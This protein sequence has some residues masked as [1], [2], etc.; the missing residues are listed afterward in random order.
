M[1]DTRSP[2]ASVRKRNRET[3]NGSAQK[4]LC[5]TVLQELECVVCM[6]HMPAHIYQCMNGHVVC[7]ECMPKLRNTC[8]TC[9]I[10]MGTTRNRALERIAACVSLPCRYSDEGCKE[11]LAGAAREAHEKTCPCRPYGCPLSAC[12]DFEG[13]K[14]GMVAHLQAPTSQGGHAVP[15]RVSFR[16]VMLHSPES[17]LD[18]TSATGYLFSDQGEDL[19]FVWTQTVHFL[20][21]CVLTFGPANELSYQLRVCARGRELQWGAPIRS[22]RERSLSVFRSNDCLAIPQSLAGWMSDAG[23]FDESDELN[24]KVDVLIARRNASLPP[25]T[26]AAAAPE[27]I[28]EAATQQ[29]LKENDHPEEDEELAIAAHEQMAE[30]TMMQG[31][32]QSP[33]QPRSLLPSMSPPQPRSLLP[34]MS[35]SPS[36]LPA[37]DNPPALSQ[38][39][40]VM[41]NIRVGNLSGNLRAWLNQ[42][43]AWG[44]IELE[45]CEIIA[46]AGT[47]PAIG[48]SRSVINMALGE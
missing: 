24:L 43:G 1:E 14:T 47:N 28:E 33:P 4:K 17:Y 16:A 20:Q 8:A 9:R 36:S 7:G 11:N 34:S 26:P 42:R 30:R 37:P 35:A 2:G 39:N 6:S 22:V 5:T 27:A 13:T 41:L 44:R 3:W 40:R 15:R 32:Q 38:D 46:T 29:A 45:V 25:T 31:Q 18:C 48:V 10:S 19:L 12:C 23:G 21:A